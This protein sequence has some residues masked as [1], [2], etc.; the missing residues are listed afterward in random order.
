MLRNLLADAG[1]T[2]DTGLIPGLGRS[3]GD[4]NANCSSILV[5]KIPWTEDS[6]YSP[7]LQS[8][9]FQRVTHD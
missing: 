1:V 8:M 7:W 9:K 6:V 3:P 5:W 4:G 2:R